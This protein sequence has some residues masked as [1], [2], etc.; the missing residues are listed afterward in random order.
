MGTH[1][2]LAV[3]QGMEGQAN[4]SKEG[5][6]T[7]DPGPGRWRDRQQTADWAGR[8]EGLGAQKSEMPMKGGGCSTDSGGR[9]ARHY[10][11]A[12]GDWCDQC[13]GQGR[14]DPA[15]EALY[16]RLLTLGP[17]PCMV[18]RQGRLITSKPET[19][20]SPN[21]PVPQPC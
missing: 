10:S 9:A 15:W 17:L 8:L 16:S 11:Q 7:L 21:P 20:V 12:F 4:C 3:I 18:S 13:P 14:A 5:G 1:K 6:Q 2:V 19:L